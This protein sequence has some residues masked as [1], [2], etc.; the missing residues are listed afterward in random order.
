MRSLRLIVE[1]GNKQEISG[2]RSKITD[3][4]HFLVGT[5]LFHHSALSLRGSP[6]MVVAP[7]AHPSQVN[8]V[9]RNQSRKK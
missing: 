3:D 8:L 5:S 7:G 9:P 2:V 1:D 6:A 4:L